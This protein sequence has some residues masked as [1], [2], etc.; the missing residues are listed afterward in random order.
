MAEH[1]RDPDEGIW[2][3]RG[4]RRY[5]THSRVMVWA[6]LD[7]AIRACEE[8]GFPGDVER[9][10][11]IAQTV[12]EEVEE[13][14]F[15]QE[16]GSFRQHY[17]TREVDASLL[18]LPAVGFIDATDERF[19]GTVERIEQELMRDGL[20]LRYRTESGIDGLEG[21]E[22]PFMICNFWLVSAYARMGRFEDAYELMDRLVALTNDVGLLAEEA[23]AEGT[24]Y[25][26][27]P[28]AFSHLGLVSAAMD[29]S[30]YAGTRPAIE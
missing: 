9:W 27:F 1:W 21:D 20:I 6:A 16:T 22:H 18:L 7:R 2:E 30:T 24:F 14:G 19:V 13:R 25:G 8:H 10:R 26:N 17:D 5:F 28:Q 15:C 3:I 29:L 11:E 23:D 4:E 12:R